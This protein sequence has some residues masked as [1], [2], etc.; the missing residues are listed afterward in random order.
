MKSPGRLSKITFSMTIESPL[1]R[2]VTLALSGPARVVWSSERTAQLV[3]QKLAA[4]PD[5]WDKPPPATERAQ[6]AVLSLN[7]WALKHLDRSPDVVDTILTQARESG[8][9]Q[10]PFLHLPSATPSFPLRLVPEEPK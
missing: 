8:D 3:E 2:P 10:H 4:P 7:D 1:M 6:D 5:W 9:R